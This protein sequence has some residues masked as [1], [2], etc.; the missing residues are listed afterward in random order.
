MGFL[1]SFVVEKLR[2]AGCAEM[3]VPRSHEYDLREKI[4]DREAFF[5]TR[6]PDV[7]YSSRGGG[8]EESARNRSN[9]GRILL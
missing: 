4:A 9:P 1:G 5:A 8:S 7:F 2:A 6:K 3:F